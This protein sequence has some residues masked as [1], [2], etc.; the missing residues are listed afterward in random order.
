MSVVNQKWGQI[1]YALFADLAPI[2]VSIDAPTGKYV[3]NIATINLPTYIKFNRDDL[4]SRW[5][6]AFSARV[7]F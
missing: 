1:D 7:R 3:Y 4:R 2:A 5:Q 6:A